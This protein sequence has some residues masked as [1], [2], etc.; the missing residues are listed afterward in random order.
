MKA[1]LF[2]TVDGE[3]TRIAAALRGL[4]G[5]VDAD[6]TTGDIDVIAAC[7]AD[8]MRVLNQTVARIRLQEGVIRTTTT[9]VISPTAESTARIAVAA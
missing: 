7:E 2:I 4:P 3:A 1:Y 8:D 5:V 9:V 6:A